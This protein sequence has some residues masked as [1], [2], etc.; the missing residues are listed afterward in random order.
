MSDDFVEFAESYDLAGDA[1]GLTKLLRELKALKREREQVRTS[2]ADEIAR[3]GNLL[4]DRLEP[5]DDRIDVLEAAAVTFLTD[6]GLK[7]TSTPVGSVQVRKPAA[8][9]VVS[10]ETQAVDWL[11]TRFPDAVKTSERVDKPAVKKALKRGAL[12]GLPDCFEMR[13]GHPFLVVVED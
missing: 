1:S 7:S 6:L 11:K 13:E 3:L 4:A 5:V 12:D 9:L 10:D 2:F 8:S